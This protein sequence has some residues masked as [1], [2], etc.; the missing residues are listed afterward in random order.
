MPC[1]KIKSWRHAL[2]HGIYLSWFPLLQ[3]TDSAYTV[4]W[5]DK[6]WTLDTGYW[7]LNVDTT[8]DKKQWTQISE[9]L[10]PKP[11]IVPL[12]H[13][14][15]LPNL[16]SC[17]F[18]SYDW[19]SYH[20][21]RQGWPRSSCG[22]QLQGAAICRYFTVLYTAIVLWHWQL[23]LNSD[24]DSRHSTLTL[25]ADMVMSLYFDTVFDNNF[26]LWHWVFILTQTLYFDTE[27]VLWY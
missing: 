24:T 5:T 11:Q 2:T 4:N 23:T 21:R 14:Q 3:N 20:L 22:Q 1:K 17:T 16:H 13:C 27:P 8:W 6:N 9:A 15:C 12:N 7:K 26:V 10:M 19:Q 25:T 18:Q